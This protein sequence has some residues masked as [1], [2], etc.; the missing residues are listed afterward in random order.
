MIQDPTL[1]TCLVQWEDPISAKSFVAIESAPQCKGFAGF[2]RA[3]ALIAE[4]L[5]FPETVT[6]TVVANG[7][8]ILDDRGQHLTISSSQPGAT[9]IFGNQIGIRVL[10]D[11]VSPEPVPPILMRQNAPGIS[12]PQIV[13]GHELGHAR[14]AVASIQRARRGLPRLP[15]DVVERN[16]Q[17]E[18]VETENI[19]RELFFPGGNKRLYDRL[20]KPPTPTFSEATKN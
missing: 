15:H 20:P 1:K 10:S 9:G 13:M 2:D 5:S 11:S 19:I 17:N 12:N 8:L 18:A 7:T 4:A 6:M 16:T 3:T 14:A